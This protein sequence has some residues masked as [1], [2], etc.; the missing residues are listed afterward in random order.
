MEEQKNKRKENLILIFLIILGLGAMILGFNQFQ[1]AIRGNFSKVADLNSEAASQDLTNPFALKIKD[2][3]SDGLTDYDEIYLYHT[4]AYLADSDSDGYKDKEEIETG[5]DPNCSSDQ[6]GLPCDNAL[7]KIDIYN[8]ST[9]QTLIESNYG[10]P[11]S[12]IDPQN[13]FS[14][15][16]SAQEIRAMLLQ[17]GMKKE[18]LDQITDEQML[19]TYSEVLTQGA[20]Q[21]NVNGNVDNNNVNLNLPA[22]FK[23]EDISAAQ[24][25]ELLLKEGA[26]KNLLDQVDDATLKQMFLE[27]MKK[28]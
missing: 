7:T 25:R 24:L 8:T 9:D 5:H 13:I 26:D 23:P 1:S 28:Q 6:S 2:T 4:S 10:S 27:S 16:A 20:D 3:D 19:Q 18:D 17:A 12:I 11:A 14:G 21:P 22:D 15:A